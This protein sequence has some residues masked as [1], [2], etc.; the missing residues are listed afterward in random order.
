MRPRCTG[1]DPGQ[2]RERDLGR[3]A[4]ADVEPGRDVDPCQLLVGHAVAAQLRQH[5]RAALGAG[6][7]ADVGQRRLE[8]AAQRVQLVAAVRGDDQRQVAAARVEASPSARATVEAELPAQP[9]QRAAI[10]VSPTTSTRGAGSTGSRKTS[11]AP[12][13]RH[14]FWTVTAPSALGHVVRRAAPS[15]LERQDPQQHRLAA[16]RSAFSA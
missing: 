10:G 3:R 9:Q 4:G 6:H 12:P 8:P 15:S 1:D 2:D 13:D 5:T 7:E 14:G 11:I 16:S